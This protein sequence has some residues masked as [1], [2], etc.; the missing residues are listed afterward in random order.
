MLVPLFTLFLTLLHKRIIH[1]TSK[2]ARLKLFKNS[3]TPISLKTLQSNQRRT[4]LEMILG[5]LK[6]QQKWTYED[7]GEITFQSTV[8]L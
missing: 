5:F 8:T 1:P 6:L 3:L 4:I 2:V 7:K